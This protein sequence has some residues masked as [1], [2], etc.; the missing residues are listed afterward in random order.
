MLKREG[1]LQQEIDER[2]ELY[3]DA[4][5]THERVH[6]RRALEKLKLIALASKIKTSQSQQNNEV[7]L[8][9]LGFLKGETSTE[10]IE[11]EKRLK[12]RIEILEDVNKDL[13]SQ[14]RAFDLKNAMLEDQIRLVDSRMQEVGGRITQAENKQIIAYEEKRK[15]V[16]DL[17]IYKVTNTQ[18]ESMIQSHVR[19]KESLLL[20]LKRY[21]KSKL[22]SNIVE[23]ELHRKEQM[24]LISKRAH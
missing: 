11:V 17:K 24:Y 21:T 20:E 6:L 5:K 12:A 10:K 15:A 7:L 13:C 14:L 23:A 2:D 22:R 16:N 1:E 18:M 8:K 4:K 9:I 19:E 3:Q